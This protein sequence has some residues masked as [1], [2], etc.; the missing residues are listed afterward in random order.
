MI[1]DEVDRILGSLA[2]DQAPLIQI[3]GVLVIFKNATAYL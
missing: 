3:S 1:P 2:D